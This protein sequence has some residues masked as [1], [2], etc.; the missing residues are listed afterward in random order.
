MLSLPRLAGLTLIR[1]LKKNP[2]LTLF[3][4]ALNRRSLRDDLQM[5]Q[6]FLLAVSL[7]LV[8]FAVTQIVTLGIKYLDAGLWSSSNSSF[9]NRRVQITSCSHRRHCAHSVC[10]AC[11]C[12]SHCTAVWLRGYINSRLFYHFLPFSQGNKGAV[13]IRFRF[14]NSDICVVNSHLAA[15]IEEFERRNQDFRDICSRLQFRQFDPTRSPLTIM[16]HE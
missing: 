13:A 7:A 3:D 12:L 2:K 14:H 10:R 4:L 1:V 8:N 16:K 9:N 5:Q 6:S 11:Q 15:H